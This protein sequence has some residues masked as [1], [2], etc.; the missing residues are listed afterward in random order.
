MTR[1]PQLGC[2]GPRE[3]GP[4]ALDEQ[5]V[6]SVARQL[7][8][9]GLLTVLQKGEQSIQITASFLPLAARRGATRHQ[10]TSL[11]NQVGAVLARSPCGFAQRT[12][13]ILETAFSQQYPG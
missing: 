13:P 8:L 7:H 9:V 2:Q 3:P 11:D 12:T 1:S 10:T 6:C 5:G 4:A